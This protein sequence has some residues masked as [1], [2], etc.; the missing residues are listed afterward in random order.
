MTLMIK[1][2]SFLGVFFCLLTLP[3]LIVVSP[4][5]ANAQIQ[6]SERDISLRTTPDTPG[7][8]E[9]AVASLRSFAVNL[10]RLRITWFI[11]GDLVKSGIGQKV[12]NFSTGPGGTNTIVEALIQV[13]EA[14]IVRKRKN[15]SPVDVDLIWEAVESY[16][17]PFS[18]QRRLPARESHVKI[19]ALPNLEAIG[20]NEIQSDMVFNWEKERQRYPEKS[21]YGKNSFLFRNDILK[22]TEEIS[23]KAISRDGNSQVEKSI[24]I[25]FIEPEIILYTVEQGFKKII[26]NNLVLEPSTN[27]KL[28]AEPYFFSVDRRSF[29]ILQY[30]WRINGQGIINSG[31]QK[32]ILEVDTTPYEGVAV[33]SLQP[34]HPQKIFQYT[35]PVTFNV[36][37]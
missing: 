14:N 10:D 21:G 19:T 18:K 17:P 13:D 29:N 37:F 23:V 3:G 25:S 36:R 27:T 8:N 4:E 6:I 15:I 28:I 35:Q 26:N 2:I 9:P 34:E 7:S 11:N 33:I 30:N 32:N 20:V 12:L 1:P 22:E 16:V 31:E 24:E 5:P